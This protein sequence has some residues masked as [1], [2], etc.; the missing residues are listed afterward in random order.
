MS[1]GFFDYQQYAIDRIAEDVSHLIASNDS[2]ESDCYGQSIGRGYKP[3]VI[4]EMRRGLAALR[5]A[6]I[7]AQRIDRLVS[8]DDGEDSFLRRLASDLE[9]AMEA[10]NG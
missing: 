6:A 1:G 3:E 7:Y 2:D 5:V 8:G 10:R 4:D 9:K